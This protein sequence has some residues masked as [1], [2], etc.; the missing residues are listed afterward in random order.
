[1]EIGKVVKWALRFGVGLG[2]LFANKKNNTQ[3][4]IV[5]WLA[6]KIMITRKKSEGNGWVGMGK[7]KGAKEVKQN[8]GHQPPNTKTIKPLIGMEMERMEARMPC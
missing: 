1:M 7:G 4:L 2:C 8:K 6:V 5:G 3:K